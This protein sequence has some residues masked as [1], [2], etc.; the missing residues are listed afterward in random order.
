MDLAQVDR[1]VIVEPSVFEETLENAPVMK[2]LRTDETTKKWRQRQNQ[3]PEIRAIIHMIKE[4]TWNY[5]RYS[6]KILSP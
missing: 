5:Y 6:K 2:S 4:D 3:D 1:T